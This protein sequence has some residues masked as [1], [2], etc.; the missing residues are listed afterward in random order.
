MAQDNVQ[1]KKGNE[2]YKKGDYKAASEYYNNALQKNAK[3]GKAQFNLGNALLKLNEP[4]LSEKAY[5]AA[6]NSRSGPS[7]QS[8]V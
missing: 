6:S 7:I 5:D 8:G 3:N 1:I 2:A 4:D